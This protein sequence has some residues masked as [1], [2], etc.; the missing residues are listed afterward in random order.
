M[1]KKIIGYKDDE[2]PND[3]S[4]WF[5]HV[6]PQDIS[7]ASAEIET[8]LRGKDANF[9]SEFR[10]RHKDGTDRWVLARGAALRDADGKAYRLAGSLTDITERTLHQEEQRRMLNDALDRADRDPLTGLFNH[11][12][13]HRR[14]NEEADRA[15]RNN[16]EIAVAIIDINNFKFFN[17]CY[18]HVSGDEVLLQVAKQLSKNCRTYDTIARYG[19][20]EFAVIVTGSPMVDGAAISQRIRD[21]VRAANFTPPGDDVSVPLAA[22]VGLAV[23]PTEAPSRHELISLADERLR[24]EKTGGGESAAIAAGIYERLKHESKGWST[25]YSLVTAVENK[26]RYTRRHSEEV[27]AYSMRIARV[28]GWDHEQIENIAVAALLHDVGKIGVPDAILRKPGKLTDFEHE[29]MKKHPE[30]GAIIVSAVPG[31]EATLPAV[32]HH[33]EAWD[34]TG[35]PD[36]LKG[37]EIPLI[38]RIMAVADAYSAMTSDRPY[39]TGMSAEKA[40]GILRAGAGK[41][42]DANCV[43]AFLES[44]PS[45]SGEPTGSFASVR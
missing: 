16:C 4:L 18:G 38:A 19:G 42:W 29:T 32:K 31:F 12:S 43:A 3:L 36:R 27:M 30:L 22:S 13:F 26:D 15:N 40:L 8:Y 20:D 6:N 14:L 35:Y 10:M 39:R 41:Q 9:A 25:L 1:C 17:D 2:L 21:A 7:R 33:H 34:G 37:E 28:L 23:Y 11:R 44:H 24:N 45:F 5:E